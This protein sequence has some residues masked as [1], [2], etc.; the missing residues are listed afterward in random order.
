MPDV[1]DAEARAVVP[2]SF[3]VT[4]SDAPGPWVLA[5]KVPSR[6]TV[7]LAPDA[8]PPPDEEVGVVTGYFS[9]DLLRHPDMPRRART[10]YVSAFGGACVCGPFTVSLVTEQM[11]RE[12]GVEST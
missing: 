2:I 7:K 10:Y 6:D 4:S 8:R 3:L 12:A 11:L 9:L 5:L 1:G